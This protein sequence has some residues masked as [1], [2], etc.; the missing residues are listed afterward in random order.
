M[1][2]VPLVVIEG[3][4][5]G[6]AG[7]WVCSVV[8]KRG[9]GQ[10]LAA[11]LVS[12][13]GLQRSVGIVGCRMLGGLGS[14]RGKRTARPTPHPTQGQPTTQHHPT[15]HTCMMPREASRSDSVSNSGTT[16]SGGLGTRCCLWV[17]VSFSTCLIVVEGRGSGGQKVRVGSGW[18]RGKQ[19]RRQVSWFHSIPS[20]THKLTMKRASRC[21]SSTASTSEARV[22]MEMT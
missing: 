5:R 12:A 18:H 16:R 8:N 19:L 7:R 10:T 3:L 11:P 2:A 1:L 4:Q 17:W 15:H 14:I 21:S 13:Q 20:H 22:A 6:W 9:G